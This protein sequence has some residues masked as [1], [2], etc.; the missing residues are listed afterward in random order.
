MTLK[1]VLFDAGDIIYHR[2]RRSIA[3]GAFLQNRGLK[4][5]PKKH[6]E[7]LALKRRAHAGEMSRDAYFEAYLALCGLEDRTAYPDGCRI[8][9][10]EQIDIDFFDGV[11]ETLHRLKASGFRL[12]IVTNTFDSTESKLRWFHKA[13]I[14]SLWDSFATSCELNLC[15]PEPGIYL[16]A[17]APL[18]LYPEEAAFVGHAATELAGAKA[19]R[20]TTVVFNGDDETV[21]ADHNIDHFTELPDAIGCVS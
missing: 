11:T 9:H 7:A 12:G 18:D 5:L 6:P 14:D 17:L 8:L 19:L 10:E 21:K 4:P 1:A 3:L 2:P 13:G 15:K 16:S 20:M